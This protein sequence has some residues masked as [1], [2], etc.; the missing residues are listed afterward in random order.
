MGLASAL[1][2]SVSGLDVASTAITVTGDNIANVNT[3]GFKER[4]AEF[5]DVLGQSIAAVGGFSQLGAGAKVQRVSSVFSQGTF[6]TTGRGTDLAIE[7]A[8]FF[9]VDSPQGRYYTRAGIF[10]FD[11]QGFLVNPEG[12]RVQGYGIDPLTGLSNGQLGDLQ[13]TTALSSPRAS[14]EMQ[15]SVNLDSAA[16]PIPGGFV[17]SDPN[18]S[19]HFR[20][21][22]TIYDTQGNGHTATLFYTKTATNTWNVTVGLAP[23]DAFDPP[24]AA[25]DQFVIQGSTQLVFDNNGMITS[26]AGAQPDGTVTIP[27]E[28]AGLAGNPVQN[29]ALSFGNTATSDVEP[30]TQLAANSTTNSFV[31]D[32]FA[33]GTLQAISIDREGFIT[34]QF[35]NGESLNLGQLALANFPNVEQL[36]AVGNNR[37]IESRGSGQPILG[38]AQS[39]SFGSIRASSLEQSNVDLAT[40]FVRLIIHQRAFQANTRT[41]SVTNELLA[42]LNNLGQ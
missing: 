34:G 5:A 7:G 22:V 25:G 30:T 18:G 3:P 27:F 32:G 17:P 24:A 13:I 4:R 37:L 2:S 11:S 35:S 9:L 41:V 29:V 39:G 31:Q 36:Q 42:T 8:G 26:V 19:S 28:F 10:N 15:L 6:E 14:T 1:F 40:Q 38:P 33:P 20:T 12:M 23:A 21:P 16:T